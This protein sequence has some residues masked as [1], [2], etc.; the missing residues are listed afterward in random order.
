MELTLRCPGSY[1]TSHLWPRLPLNDEKIRQAIVNNVNPAIAGYILN[2]SDPIFRQFLEGVFQL[3]YALDALKTGYSEQFTPF[4]NVP[5]P[6][7]IMPN[8]PP[9]QLPPPPIQIPPPPGASQ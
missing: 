4:D 7:V 6:D 8:I 9:I 3:S 5:A 2:F 1:Q